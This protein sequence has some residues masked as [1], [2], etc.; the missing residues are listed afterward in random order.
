MIYE[1]FGL[2]YIFYFFII[3]KPIVVGIKVKK[4]ISSKN[5]RLYFNNI[6]MR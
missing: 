6:I 5:L 4:F 1:V 2:F 3:K